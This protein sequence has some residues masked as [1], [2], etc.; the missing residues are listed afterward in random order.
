MSISRY[1]ICGRY[2]LPN[3]T[4]HWTEEHTSQHYLQRSRGRM[5]CQELLVSQE[6]LT[7][8]PVLV[9]PLLSL[10]QSSLMIHQFIRMSF[11]PVVDDTFWSKMF[12]LWPHFISTFTT[13]ETLSMTLHII[14]QTTVSLCSMVLLLS[15]GLS[16]TEL[17]IPDS[18]WQDQSY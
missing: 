15:T 13:M 12:I 14:H 2:L 3:L 18:S 9:H 17:S 1:W 16:A 11:S 4:K 7:K 8:F 5:Q 10:H 6:L